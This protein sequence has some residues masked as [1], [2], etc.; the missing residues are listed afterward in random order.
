M[1]GP[2]SPKVADLGWGVVDVEGVGRFKDVILYPG[3]AV[4]WDWGVTG[5]RHRPGIQPSDV[6]QVVAVTG[7]EATVVGIEVLVLSRGMESRLGVHED[8]VRYAESLGMEVHVAP[9]EDAV[10]LYN[11]VAATRAVAALIHSTC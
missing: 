7:A 9:T 3:G 10:A 2:S 8:T 5:T 1:G 6:D 11:E 4:G